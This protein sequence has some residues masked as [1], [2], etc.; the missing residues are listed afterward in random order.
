MLR[1][2]P[3]AGSC[4]PALQHFGERDAVE[5]EMKVVAQGGLGVASAARGSPDDPVRDVQAE[6]PIECQRGRH[7][8]DHELQPVEDA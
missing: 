7:V 8:A 4:H 2:P 3:R 5:L 1:L 6:A